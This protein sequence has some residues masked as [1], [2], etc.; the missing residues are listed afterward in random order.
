MII[1][2]DAEKA[3]DKIQH[4]R[5]KFKGDNKHHHV[6]VSV[7][8]TIH[9]PPRTPSWPNVYICLRQLGI[10]EGQLVTGVMVQYLTIPLG[11]ACPQLVNKTSEGSDVMSTVQC[12]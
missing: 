2:I 8:T 4:T 1:A 11:R 6:I 9:W 10:S 12:V 5:D 3:F 7:T